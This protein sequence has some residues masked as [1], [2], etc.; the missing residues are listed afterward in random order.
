MMGVSTVARSGRVG[1]SGSGETS[2]ELA[3]P[4]RACDGISMD[5]ASSELTVQAVGAGGSMVEIPSLIWL[6]LC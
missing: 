5:D 4:M 1:S 6:S 3:H 2:D